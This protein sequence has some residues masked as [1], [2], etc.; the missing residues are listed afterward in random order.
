[1]S[2]F[3]SNTVCLI[4]QGR[5]AGKKCVVVEAHDNL[6]TVVGIA[7]FP[8]VIRTNMNQKQ[9][10]RRSKL[11]TFIKVYHAIHLMPTRYSHKQAFSAA[12]NS[13]SLKEA[14]LKKAAL[15]TVQTKLQEEYIQG[16]DSWLFKKLPF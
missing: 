9:A 5:H 12:V 10:E 13:K 14:N 16:S 1:M 6:V 15:A 4:L 8:R 2:I 3:K 7:S 11:A